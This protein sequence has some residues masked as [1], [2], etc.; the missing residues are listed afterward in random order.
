M[1]MIPSVRRKRL[2]VLL[3]PVVFLAALWGIPLDGTNP[4]AG[5]TLAVGALMAFYWITD[6]I[7]LSVTAMIPVVL[8]PLLGI[9]KGRDVAPLYFNDVIFLFLGGF[10]VALAMERWN[11]HKRIALRIIL[12]AGGGQGRL[13]LGFMAGAWF[14]SMWMSNTATAMMIVPIVLALLLKLEEGPNRGVRRFQTALLLGVAYASSIGGM[15]TL[16]GTPPNLAFAKIFA[17][18][19]PE[20]PEMTFVRWAA[21]AA[22]FSLCFI[23]L[24]YAYL[25]FLFLRGVV[26][27]IDSSMLAKEYEDL[28]KPS[29]EE[30]V[31]FAAF[32]ALALLWMTRSN[33]DIGSVTVP[34]WSSLLGDPSF[35]DDGTVAVLVSIG[36]FLIPARSDSGAIMDWETAKKL[37]WHIVLLFGGGFALANGFHDS[38]LSAILGEK[39]SAI[40]GLP[41]VLILLCVCTLV[42]FL[43]ELTSNTATT[44]VVLPIIAA[45]SAVVR[46]HPLYLMVPATISASCAFMLPVA[47]PPN[48]IIFGTNRL[49][50]SDMAKTGF[51]LNLLGIVLVTLFMLILGNPVFGTDVPVMPR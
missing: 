6:A 41:P 30:K 40:Q 33:V 16:I 8:F 17:I 23:I 21:F 7:P 3:G 25:R 14:L 15:A 32:L 49:L 28:D 35:V 39:L 20:G 37:P 44:Q 38:G 9:M 11:L 19:F 46:I 22:P 48:A 42:T 18:S 31:V 5:R 50:A 45:L 1:D 36:L 51:F 27:T 34:G 10:I 24:T 43:T 13:M 29:Y 2:Y 12:A 26:L 4:A 47:T